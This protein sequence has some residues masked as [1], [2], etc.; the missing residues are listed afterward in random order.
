MKQKETEMV[1]AYLRQGSEVFINPDLIVLLEKLDD[2]IEV[3]MLNGKVY[4]LSSSCYE[5]L[6]GEK[7][8]KVPGRAGFDVL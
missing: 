6:T 7:A 1:R 5:K 4:Q 8:V 2:F 3:T